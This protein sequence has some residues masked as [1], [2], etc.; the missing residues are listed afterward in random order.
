MEI[1]YVIDH[2]VV[3]NN[4]C[5]IFLCEIQVVP[6]DA[7]HDT[8][9]ERS[10]DIESRSCDKIVILLLG[11]FSVTLNFVSNVGAN[12]RKSDNHEK[13]TAYFRRYSSQKRRGITART[14]FKSLRCAETPKG[15]F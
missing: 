3:I 14:Y 2:G 1:K 7:Q 13:T 9:D 12:T 11:G 15:S 10:I 4:E 5:V 6:G 8:E